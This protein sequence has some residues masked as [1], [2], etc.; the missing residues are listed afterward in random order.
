MREF[1]AIGNVDYSSTSSATVHGD[2]DNSYTATTDVIDASATSSTTTSRIHGTQLD[3]TDDV[4]TGG[5]NVNTAG[6]PNVNSGPI[7]D[8]TIWR[9]DGTQSVTHCV[10]ACASNHTSDA[11]R[12]TFGTGSTN[13][14]FSATNLC[15]CNDASAPSAA[16]VDL[17]PLPRG[18]RGAGHTQRWFQVGPFSHVARAGLRR[19]LADHVAA[20]AF[21]T[22]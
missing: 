18:D 7:D 3:A 2:T 22:I 19:S 12:T 9:P 11:N 4:N 8:P 1:H 5:A 15:H 20:A 13:G 21:A 16:L 6:A 17:A 10:R 14:N